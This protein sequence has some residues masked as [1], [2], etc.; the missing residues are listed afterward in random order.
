MLC[1]SER[2]DGKIVEIQ[3]QCKTV[4]KFKN[5]CANRL[6]HISVS[7]KR[8]PFHFIHWQQLLSFSNVHCVQIS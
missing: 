5:R 2:K 7:K 3:L 8:V 1:F 6:K 4:L